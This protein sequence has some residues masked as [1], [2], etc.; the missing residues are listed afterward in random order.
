MN[1]QEHFIFAFGIFFPF[2]MKIFFPKNIQNQLRLVVVYCY[3]R[4][5]EKKNKNAESVVRSSLIFSLALIYC[6]A[7]QMADVPL[8]EVRTLP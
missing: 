4:S 2:N 3:K 8:E 7:K 6:K 5:Q 1:L